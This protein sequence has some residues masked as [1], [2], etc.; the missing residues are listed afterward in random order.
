[1]EDIMKTLSLRKQQGQV[2]VVVAISLVMLVG[3]VGLAV[4]SGMGYLVRAKLNAA[5]DAAALAGA[6]AAP[7]GRNRGEQIAAA[8]D[9]AE[10]FFAANYPR[11]YLGSNVDLRDVN[12]SFDDPTPGRIT[13]DVNARANVPVTF[14]GILGFRQL[15]IDASSQTIRKDL[16]LAFVVDTSGSVNPVAAEVRAQSAAFLDRFAPTSDR[17]SLIHFSAGAEVDEPIRTGNNRGFNRDRM[18]NI[19]RSFHF[20]G[21][22]NSAE[23]MWQARRQLNSIAPGN[24]SSMRVIVFFSDGSP[25]TFASFFRF[26]N[27]GLCNRAG[28]ISSSD[29][30]TGAPYGLRD[31]TRQDAN[32]AGGCHQGSGITARLTASALPNWYNAH[33]INDREFQVVTNAPRVVTNDT[34]TPAIAYANINRASKNLAEAMA[35]RARA[36]GIHVF[37][38]GLGAQ[39]KQ[40]T[41]AST[42]AEDTGENLLKCMANAADAPARCRAAGASQPTGVYCHAATADGLQPCFSTLASEILRL[43]R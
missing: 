29:A 33:D 11:N 16:D 25:N 15:D 39:L 38:L 12:V 17:V 5:A 10:K 21:L 43:T 23:G 13:V 30:S 24:R 9:A 18:I 1:V 41:G 35:A 27:P 32:A 34:S 14:M 42:S 6:R 7:K 40:V 8:T 28:A 4:D 31:H 26:R 36:E 22:T 20:S 19:I 2:F 37:T 3:A